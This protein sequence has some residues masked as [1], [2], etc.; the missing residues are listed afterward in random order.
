MRP[1]VLVPPQSR[2]FVRFNLKKPKQFKSGP[3]GGLRLKR[4]SKFR[5]KPLS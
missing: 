2:N 4:K 5:A 3:G 1:L